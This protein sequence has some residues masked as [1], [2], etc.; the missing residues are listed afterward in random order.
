MRTAAARFFDYRISKALRLLESLHHQRDETIEKLKVA[1]KY[2]STQ[3]LLEKYGAD[4]P[5]TPSTPD[6][7]SPRQGGS[8]TNKQQQQQQKTSQSSDFARTGLSPPPTANIVRLQHSVSPPPAS[9]AASPL[10]PSPAGVSLQSSSSGESN[11]APNAFSSQAQYVEQPASHW[12]D[13]LLDVLLGEDETQPQNRIVLI[14]K[15]CRLVNGQAPPGVKA[16]EALGQWRCGSC[17]AWNGEESEAKSVL[18]LADSTKAG[19]RAVLHNETETETETESA[20]VDKVT[21]GEKKEP[22]DDHDG[23]NE[24]PKELG[25]DSASE[26]E[27]ADKNED[28]AKSKS[29]RPRR[30]KKG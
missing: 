10:N 5:A 21:N 30:S 16:L 4:S 13:R 11:F 23:H 18:A 26:A 15:Q 29:S 14:C 25:N 28:L 12:Y 7:K 2:N 8:A 17:G 9:V 1:T 3:Q 6:K 19:R 27:D 24:R 22:D 20:R